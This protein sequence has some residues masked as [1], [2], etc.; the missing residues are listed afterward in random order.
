MITILKECKARDV[1][2]RENGGMGGKRLTRTN[3]DEV[4]SGGGIC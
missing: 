3:F 1:A 2:F 4:E